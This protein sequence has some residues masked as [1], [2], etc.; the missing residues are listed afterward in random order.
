M[1]PCCQSW[2]APSTLSMPSSTRPSGWVPPGKT[3]SHALPTFALFATDVDGDAARA[4]ARGVVAF[5]LAAVGPTP[6]SGVY[7]ANEALVDMLERGGPETVA[8]EMPDEWL[9]QFAI[10]GTPAECAGRIESLLE[11]GAT[12]VVL[13]PTSPDQSRLFLELAAREVLPKV[14]A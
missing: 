1:A 14:G 3:G 10:A 2:R 8:N 13:F 6:L 7:D 11:A 12:S 5:Y 4:A 9:D